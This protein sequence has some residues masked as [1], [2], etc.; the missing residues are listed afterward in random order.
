MSSVF[1]KPLLLTL[2]PCVS[3]AFGIQGLVA[4]P[5]MVARSERYYDLSGSLTYLSCTALSLALPV[6]R[7]RRSGAV[8]GLGTALT[9]KGSA[10]A[11]WNWRQVALGAAVGVWATRCTSGRANSMTNSSHSPVAQNPPHA[12]QI[13][14]MITNLLSPRTQ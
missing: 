9:G 1:S 2:V 8:A 3:L 14:D 7:A 4:V 13:Y 10:A 5:S 12:S 6:M 11:T